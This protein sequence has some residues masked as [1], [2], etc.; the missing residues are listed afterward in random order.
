[1]TPLVV[2]HSVQRCFPQ[3]LQSRVCSWQTTAPQSSQTA[4]VGFSQ[5]VHFRVSSQIILPVAPW[6]I[7]R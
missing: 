1:M 4:R 2:T 6:R 7:F 5:R 3:L